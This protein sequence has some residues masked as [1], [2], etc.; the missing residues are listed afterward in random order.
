MAHERFDIWEEHSTGALT[1]KL[2]WRAQLIGAVAYFPTKESAERFV[3]RSA[4]G[5]GAAGS[6][7]D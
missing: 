4:E 5:Q 7:I 1:S 6:E 3:D 2:P